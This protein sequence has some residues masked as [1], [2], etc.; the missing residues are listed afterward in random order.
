M[1]TAFATP[2]QTATVWNLDPAHTDIG[3]AVKHL[4][5]TNVKGRFEK[6]T[7]TIELDQE[8][9][10]RSSAHVEIDVTSIDTRQSGR[11]EHLRS[12]DFFDAENHPKIVFESRRIERVKDDR[13][14]LLGD[15]TIRGTTRPVTLDAEITG[16]SSDPWGGVR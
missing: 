3:F 2:S 16:P 4:M 5:V 9:L 1:S 10:T 12:A 15:L 8:D 6:A 11:D 13:Y 7:G 14:R